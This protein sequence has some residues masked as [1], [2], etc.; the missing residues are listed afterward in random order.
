MRYIYQGVFKDGNGVVVGSDWS[1]RVTVYLAGTTTLATIYTASS[2]GSADS[3]SI[4]APDN[5]GFFSFYIDEADYLHS[6]LFK[7]TLT[8]TNF[9]S[10]SYDNLQIFPRRVLNTASKT[11]TYTV[12]LADD[13]VFCNGTFTVTLPAVA[14][15][16]GK[17]ITIK[18]TGSGTIT[19]SPNIEGSGLTLSQYQVL[20]IISDGSNYYR[21]SHYA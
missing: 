11:T 9:E 3:D 10:K 13:I 2:G 5:S 17:P 20:T 19:I 15:T 4:I 1:P 18:N 14:T 6:Q 12:T 8:A 16:T 21:M 7:I